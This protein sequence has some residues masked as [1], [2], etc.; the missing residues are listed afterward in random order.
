MIIIVKFSIE[1]IRSPRTTVPDP[2]IEVKNP[3]QEYK[4]YQADPKNAKAK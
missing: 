3:M 1:N 4:Q 2:S